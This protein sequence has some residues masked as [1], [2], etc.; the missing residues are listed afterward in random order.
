MQHHYRPTTTTTNHGIYDDDSP[1]EVCR[2]VLRD[3]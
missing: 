3:W 2:F 1:S